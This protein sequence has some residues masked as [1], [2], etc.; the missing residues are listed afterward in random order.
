M[1]RKLYIHLLSLVIIFSALWFYLTVPFYA[2][3]FS[4]LE[5]F[6][7]VKNI[8]SEVLK[9]TAIFY[10]IY[11]FLLVH[12]AK[13]NSKL[14]QILLAVRNKKLMSNDWR[15]IRY[16]LVKLF[17]I[18]LMLPPA[19]I[20]LKLFLEL[21]QSY[22]EYGSFIELF[23]K[24]IFSLIIYG[25]SF[26]TLAY[27]SFGYLIESKKLNS[28]VKSVDK[29]FFGWVVLAICYVPFFLFMTQY[30]P[31]PT[32]D[33]AF[34]I[35]QEVTFIVRVLLSFLMLFKMYSVMNLGAKCSN[36]TNRGI[37]TTGPYQ[38]IRHPHYLAKLLIWW[39]TFLPYLI[40]HYWA[41][42]A[43]VFWSVVYFLRALTEEIHLSKDLEYK[44][45]KK[46]V[47]WMFIP[48]VV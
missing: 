35:N 42:G 43:M 26:V 39:I 20:Y 22:E 1:Q 31:F 38:Y 46:Q 30:I 7:I 18:P 33:Y 6:F 44:A 37:V 27:Y 29:T 19:I 5:G 23:N 28:T 21:L 47:K 24:Y 17:F 40:H 3:Q 11:Q 8:H 45:Y 9:I 32:Q 13:G 14:E 15:N 16:G 36:L 41:I 25:V 4:E 10:A 34:F 2:L 12:K 48:Y